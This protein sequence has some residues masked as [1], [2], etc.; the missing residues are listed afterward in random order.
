MRQTICL[1]CGAPIGG[2][3]D[4]RIPRW[5]AHDACWDSRGGDPYGTLGREIRDHNTP[6]DAEDAAPKNIEEEK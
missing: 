2:V 1:I 3:P 5:G 6:L 4:P